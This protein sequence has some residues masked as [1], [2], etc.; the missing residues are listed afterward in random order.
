MNERTN[1]RTKRLDD[2]AAGTARWAERERPGTPIRRQKKPANSQANERNSIPT[3]SSGFSFRE[4]VD[5]TVRC[6]ALRCVVLY[7]AE[8]GK[9]K[10]KEKEKRVLTSYVQFVL[11]SALRLFSI[12]CNCDW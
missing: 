3:Y 11:M 2:C 8:K 1:E 6:V 7:R 10:E 4:I 9:E 5:P 12:F